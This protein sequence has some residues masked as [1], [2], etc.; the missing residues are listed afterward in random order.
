MNSRRYELTVAQ[1]YR[2]MDILDDKPEE[3]K[4][5]F[6]IW[7]IEVTRFDVLCYTCKI[8]GSPL[9]RASNEKLE[10]GDYC[11]YLDDGNGGPGGLKIIGPWASPTFRKLEIGTL[12]MLKNVPTAKNKLEHVSNLCP[13]RPNWF[14]RELEHLD[15]RTY[16]RS[17]GE[18]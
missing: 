8:I 18:G 11:A 14:L 7:R 12:Q 6:L 4:F 9:P 13:M 10:P 15:G 17:Q 2:W 5:N 16:P 1:F 3:P